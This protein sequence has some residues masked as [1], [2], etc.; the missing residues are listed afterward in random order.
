MELSDQQQAF[1][2]GLLDKIGIR[3]H[4]LE[5]NKQPSEV[6][7]SRQSQTMCF[8]AT[9]IHLTSL[10]N[11]EFLNPL[12][13]FLYAQG[14]VDRGVLCNE[15]FIAMHSTA[16]VSMVTVIEEVIKRVV[17]DDCRRKWNT[18]LVSNHN[19]FDSCLQAHMRNERGMDYRLQGRVD[20]T[21]SWEGRLLVRSHQQH[22]P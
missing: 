11:G 12:K 9:G 21:L 8:S 22:F 14:S 20:M 7:A 6:S 19:A 3:C 16:V 4:D 5:L 1:S 2:K 13:L 18:D 17:Y 15:A 10:E